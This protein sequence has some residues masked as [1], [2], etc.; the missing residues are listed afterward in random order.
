VPFGCIALLDSVALGSW[1][2]PTTRHVKEHLDV[3]RSMPTEVVE[4]VVTSH[5]RTATHR[6]MDEATLATYLEGW[7]GELRQKLYLQTAGQLRVEDTAVF[8]PLLAS[9]AVPG[10]IDWGEHDAWL[11]PVLAKR[12]HEPIPSSD[13]VLLP[14]PGHLT[15]DD[16]LREVAATL[17]DSFSGCS[18]IVAM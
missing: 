8:E 16:S 18:D 7:K 9:I 1:I 4:A 5:L 6:P 3:H 12:P 11:S 17:F 2:T 13:L 15:T 14:E 10:H